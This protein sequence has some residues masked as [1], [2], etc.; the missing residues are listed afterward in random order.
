MQPNQPQPLFRSHLSRT[1]L[2][3][4]LRMH[5]RTSIPL[6]INLSSNIRPPRIRSNLRKRSIKNII[7]TTASITRRSTST[8]SMRTKRRR[9]RRSQLIRRTLWSRTSTRMRTRKLWRALSLPKTSSEPRWRLHKLCQRSMPS[10]QWSTMSRRAIVLSPRRIRVMLI[11]VTLWMRNLPQVISRTFKLKIGIQMKIKKLWRVSNMP[12]INL[13]PKW[14]SLKPFQK[15]M[16]LH[17][18]SMTSKN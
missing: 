4:P 6:S 8:T 10:P 13:V 2:R 15:S 7:I 9:M 3:M 1:R 11:W 18:L 5:L 12:R 16:L 14:Q 17:Q